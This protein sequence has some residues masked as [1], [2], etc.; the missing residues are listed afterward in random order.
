MHTL[1]TALAL[2]TLTAP[3][4]TPAQDLASQLQQA[5]I[6]NNL[7]AAANARAQMFTSLGSIQGSSNSVT[8]AEKG[9]EG[10]HMRYS[11]YRA[12]LDVLKL[13][14]PCASGRPAP[15]VVIGNAPPSISLWESFLNDRAT[16]EAG[17]ARALHDW[18]TVCYVNKTCQTKFPKHVAVSTRLVAPVAA[19]IAVAV[20]NLLKT[21]TTT[22][23]ATIK[24]ADGEFAALVSEQFSDCP[25]DAASAGI[26]S[27]A[28][29]A[30]SSLESYPTAAGATL[31]ELRDLAGK[32]NIEFQNLIA[33]AGGKADAIGDDN[34]VNAG[35]NLEA[36]ISSYDALRKTLFTDN[37]GKLTALLLEKQSRIAGWVTDH[38]FPIV[39]I[40]NHDAALT[41]RTRK[42]ASTLVRAP[43]DLSA[44]A[45]IN[46]A[47]VKSHT[48]VE[49]K[50][51]SCST[52]PIYVRKGKLDDINQ[53]ECTTQI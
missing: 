32:K 52:G 36:L 12:A 28:A 46:Y 51:I 44:L 17:F 38:A 33:I 39:Y 41:T 22:T 49:R 10:V 13:T 35:H 42:G 5:Q 24:S 40:L 18:N 16:L 11:V 2:V 29:F 37:G 45:L 3:A 6:D 19:A 14:A 4:A 9:V 8:S 15:L 47:I 34:L 43:A 23:G 1:R 53:P 48:V 7:A 30:T 31:G 21:D 20:V 27:G 25:F 26:E 50:T